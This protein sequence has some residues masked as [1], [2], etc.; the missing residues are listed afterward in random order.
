[1]LPDIIF[2][3]L[4]SYNNILTDQ[5]V[6]VFYIIAGEFAVMRDDFQCE[7][8]RRGTGFAIAIAKTVIYLE[9]PVKITKHFL[10]LLID[11]FQPRR[12]AEF[13]KK[14]GIALHL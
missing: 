8:D 6:K 9:V 14:D 2:Q 1:M 7:V 3:Q 4:V 12:A 5:L 10:Y 11:F 13:V